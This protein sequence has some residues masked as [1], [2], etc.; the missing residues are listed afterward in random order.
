MKNC[1]ARG[2]KWKTATLDNSQL[3]GPPLER[4][5]SARRVKID[6][7]YRLFGQSPLACGAPRAIQQTF[8]AAPPPTNSRKPSDGSAFRN[9]GEGPRA[10]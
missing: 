5:H 7:I 6:A 2:T 8:K 10:S 1:T 4:R 3:D 9:A